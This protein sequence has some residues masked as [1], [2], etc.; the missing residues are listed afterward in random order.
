MAKYARPHDGE[1]ARL[2][3]QRGAYTTSN[4]AQ[5]RAWARE[6]F[7]DESFA[8]AAEPAPNLDTD[9][10]AFDAGAFDP[11]VLDDVDDLEDEDLDEINARL[12]KRGEL[13]G[14]SSSAGGKHASH[15]A[16]L[17][18]E[19]SGQSR[20]AAL[21]WISHSPRGQALFRRTLSKRQQ[22]QTK[23]KHMPETFAKMV[24]DAGI[25]AV[26]KAIVD[27][28]YSSA[29]S[30][31]E[32]TS[33]VTEYA[34]RAYPGL[35]PALAFEKIYCDQSADGE[36]LR[37]AQAVLRDSAWHQAPALTQSVG[38][39]ASGGGAYAQLLVK[40]ET[41]AAAEGTTVSQAFAKIYVAPENREL[42]AR[43]RSENRPVA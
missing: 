33:A 42:A 5:A 8:N 30:E 16:D 40:A 25:V 6:D 31:T 2:A 14:D 13:G 39:Q 27:H 12:D 26:A 19:S 32:F 10:D 41:L 3:K 23:E 34:K 35:Q 15:L 21:G 9:P 17:I 28:R 4:E 24:A 29:V 1:I 37:R 22:Q 36:A 11:N 20:Q 7:N 43:E 18:S 38:K